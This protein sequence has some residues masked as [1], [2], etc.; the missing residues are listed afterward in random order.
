MPTR[1]SYG[2]NC[3]LDAGAYAGAAPAGRAAPGDPRTTRRM[4]GNRRRTTAS[5]PLP[6]RSSSRYEPLAHVAVRPVGH[7]SRCAPWMRNPHEE[8]P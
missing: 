4:A 5:S 6:R 1:E 7:A 8:K 3:V 2:V